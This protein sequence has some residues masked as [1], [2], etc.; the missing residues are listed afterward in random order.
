MYKRQGRARALGVD[1]HDRAA[2]ALGGLQEG[3]E[4]GRGAGRVVAPDEDDFGVGRVGV[5]H[6][7]ARAERGLHGVLGRRAADGP[8]ELAGAEAVPEAAAA[9]AHVDQPQRAAIAIG[10]DGRRP[11]LGDDAPP[12]VADLADGLIPANPRPFARSLRP[13]APQR[14]YQPVGVIDVV[15]VRPHLAAQPAVGDGVVGV[16][17]EGH[18]PALAVLGHLHLNDRAA[19]VGAVVGAGAA[20]EGGVRGRAIGIAW[21][22]GRRGW[23][24]Q[25]GDL[26]FGRVCASNGQL[27]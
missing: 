2:V 25:D 14:V 19:G 15:E 11:V 26:V 21:A 22:V 20:D 18:G 10:Q 17:I 16:A 9:D 27:S 1:D 3:H 5:G 12:A 13:H 8:V 7:P 24:D 6:G 23:S 4:V